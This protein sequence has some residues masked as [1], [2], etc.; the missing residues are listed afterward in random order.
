MACSSQKAV[1]FIKLLKWLQKEYFYFNVPLNPQ[2]MCANNSFTALKLVANNFSQSNYAMQKKSIIF[3]AMHQEH[4][5]TCTLHTSGDQALHQW[6]SCIIRH[7][8]TILKTHLKQTMIDV[9]PGMLGTTNT[10][11]KILSNPLRLS[12]PQIKPHPRERT[13]KVDIKR[14]KETNNKIHLN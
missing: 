13:A 7:G 11:I 14:N 10:R 1:F 3:Q 5:H 6:W 2:F 9:K 4:L 12:I 8:A